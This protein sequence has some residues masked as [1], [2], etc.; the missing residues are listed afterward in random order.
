MNRK[1]IIVQ[2]QRSARQDLVGNRRRK[3]SSRTYLNGNSGFQFRVPTTV[4]FPANVIGFP[5][6]L[7]TT[8]KY[9]QAIN[10]G[11]NAAPS[12]QIFTVNS[13]FDPD[14]SGTGHQPSFFDTFSSIYGRYYV[15]A[16]QFDVSLVNDT[17]TEGAYYVV[18]YSDQNNGSQTL[19]QLSEGKYAVT[20]VLGTSN[21]VSTKRI[22]LPWMP[23]AQLMGAPN[24]RMN[25]VDD[26]MYAPISSSPIDLAYGI[27]KVASVDGTTAI[28]V[29]ARCVITMRVVFKDLLPQVSS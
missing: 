9:S 8:L 26:N 21:A 24:R 29:R 27:L 20:G 13:A 19:E 12:A 6:R 22:S 5:D 25:E 4:A 1:A 23:I 2:T 28:T 18:S 14:N 15:E 16:V 11:P 17:S 10:L 7:K 3:E